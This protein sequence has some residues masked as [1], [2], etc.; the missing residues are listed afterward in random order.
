M[1]ILSG[2]IIAP[3]NPIILSCECVAKVSAP[4]INMMKL[5]PITR[6]MF[7]FLV[8]LRHQGTVVTSSVLPIITASRISPI[9]ELILLL[10]P[11]LALKSLLVWS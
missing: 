5:N 6:V 9:S 4:E 8:L 1:S 11:H 2:G 10:S 3:S 7:L